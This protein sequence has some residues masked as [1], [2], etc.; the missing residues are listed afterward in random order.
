MQ[1]FK[2]MT[3]NIKLPSGYQEVEYLESTGTQYIDTNVVIN[4][5]SKMV[6]ENQFTDTSAQ[7]NGVYTSSAMRF[8]FGILSDK[9]YIGLGSKSQYFNLPADTSKHIWVNDLLNKTCSIDTETY[10]DSSITST[11]N[12]L[13]FLLFVRTNSSETNR[14]YYCKER[15][16]SCQIYDNNVIIRNFI[17]CYRKSDNKPGLYDSV[18]KVFYTNQGSDEF[19]LGSAT[20]L[21]SEYQQVEYIESTGTQWIDSGVIGNSN[22]KIVSKLSFNPNVDVQIMGSGWLADQRINFGK[23]TGNNTYSIAIGSWLNSSITLDNNYHLIEVDVPNKIGKIDNETLDFSSYSYTGENQNIGIFAR[24]RTGDVDYYCNSKCKTFQIYDNNVLVRNFIPCYRKSDNEIGLYDLVTKSFYTNQGTGTFFKGG[25]ITDKYKIQQWKLPDEYTELEYLESTGTQYIDTGIYVHSSD[26]VKCKF[27]VL[28]STSSMADAIYGCYSSAIKNFF[29]LL[30]RSPSNA[31]V[32]T[33]SNQ[34]S[35]T[36]YEL[37][38]VYDTTLTNGTYIENGTTYTFTPSADFTQPVTFWVMS[39]NQANG[40]PISAKVYSFEIEG[41][42]NG[43]PC[44]RNSDNALG[45]YDIVSRTFFENAGTGS[46]IAGNS[47][48]N[49]NKFKI[50]AGRLPD[51]YQEVEYIESTGTQYIDTN[52]GSTENTGCIID[53]QFANTNGQILSGVLEAGLGRFIPCLVEGGVI[54]SSTQVQNVTIEC[55]S[56]NI[57]DRH[58]CEYNINNKKIIFDGIEK[59]TVGSIGATEN[60]IYIF[61]RNYTASPFYSDVKVYSYKI[62]ENGTITRN[63]VPCY[64]KSD[65]EIGLYDVLNNT[66]YTN[67]GTGTF[68]KG[69]NM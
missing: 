13:K 59:G 10:S 6:C 1:K 51:E 4:S 23:R 25:I 43:I 61:C 56:T 48:D 14:D 67:A 42:F 12:I 18:N 3:G 27:E 60:H 5:N 35:S 7:L 39:R 45:L 28:S 53:F 41:K 34:A 22:T 69:N 44:R 49:N 40:V 20:S 15:I 26:V 11:S 17:P 19:I 50:K 33:S 55:L 63:F 8:Q 30:M 66:F 36:N 58:T 31:R 21:P 38:K 65:N 29:V 54:K 62:Y 52:V 37:N 57:T 2:V 64:R 24:I 9:F 46:F 32:G 68:L 47:K 16:Y